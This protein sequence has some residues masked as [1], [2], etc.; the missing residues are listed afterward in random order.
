MWGALAKLG[1]AILATVGIDYA[2]DSYKE[3]QAAAAADE[4][5]AKIGKILVG[6]AALFV[7]YQLLKRM[8]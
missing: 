3:N 7:G 6:A 1:G 4:K 2:V 8:K 5:D